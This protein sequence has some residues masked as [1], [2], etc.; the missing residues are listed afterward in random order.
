MYQ[1]IVLQI[2]INVT[3]NFTT[4]ILDFCLFIGQYAFRSRNDSYTQTVL[5]TAEITWFCIMAQ[6]RTA[7][8]FKALNSRLFC[9]TVIFQSN[10]YKALLV[11]ILKLIFK[12]ITLVVQD[13]SHALF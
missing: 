3:K 7:Y 5:Y 11:I 9:L 12:N 2:L 10:F 6:T 8:S 4:Y 1:K 13:L